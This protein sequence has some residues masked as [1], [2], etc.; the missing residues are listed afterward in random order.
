MKNWIRLAIMFIVVIFL[1]IGCNASAEIAPSSTPPTPTTPTQTP[2]NTITTT[3]TPLTPEPSTLVNRV[4]F[5][6][7]HPKRRCA[8][9]LAI[10]TLTKAYLETHYQDQMESG[11]LTF[12]SYELEDSNNAAVVKKFKPVGSSLFINIIKDSKENIQPVDE[13]WLPQI[14]NDGQAFDNFMNKLVSDSLQEIE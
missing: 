14:Y 2:S 11:K 8:T 4:D 10:E 13:V 5:A 12:T 1:A 7:F 3:V 6:Y 9:C